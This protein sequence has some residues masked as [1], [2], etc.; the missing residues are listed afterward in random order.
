MSAGSHSLHGQH[1]HEGQ[2]YG[3]RCAWKWEYG[4]G[5]WARPRTLSVKAPAC[6]PYSCELGTLENAGLGILRPSD[7]SAFH[8]ASWP[9]VAQ[10]SGPLLDFVTQEDAKLGD[11][12]GPF[13]VLTLSRVPMCRLTS[14][15]N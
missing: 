5:Q 2:R 11:L 10:P 6:S 9:G 13:A 3:G 15:S 8:T 12:P 1:V 14:V 7:G 4:S